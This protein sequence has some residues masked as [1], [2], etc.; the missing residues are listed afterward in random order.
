MADAICYNACKIANDV[1]ASAI[2]AMSRSGYSAMRISSFRP[3]AHILVIMDDQEQLN[4]L[5]MVWGV[6]TF[7]YDKMRSTDETIEEVK[8]MLKQEG[9][10]Q[11]GD[12][13]VN[14]ASMPLHWKGTTNMLKLSRIE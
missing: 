10:L 3:S 2:I 9:M 14:T 1:N 8:E 6:R 12:I 11:K 5:S 7:C 4:T 13:V